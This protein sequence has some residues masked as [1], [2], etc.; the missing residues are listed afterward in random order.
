MRRGSVGRMADYPVMQ[1]RDGVWRVQ[2][3]LAEAG[4]DFADLVEAA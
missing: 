3:L 1:T 2:R 4:V